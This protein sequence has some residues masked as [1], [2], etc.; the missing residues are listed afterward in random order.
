[1]NRGALA[2]PSVKAAIEASQNGDRKT[3]SALFDP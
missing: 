3:W 1:M 2:N